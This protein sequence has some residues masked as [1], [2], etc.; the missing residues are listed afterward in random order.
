MTRRS[1]EQWLHDLKAG[2]EA[3]SAALADLRA[4]LLSGLPYAL[5]RW[6]SPSDPSFE[7]L[8][9]ETA[10]DALLKILD[11]LHTFEGRSQFTTWA[12]KIAVN[13]ALSKLRR[14]Q[15]QDVSLDELVGEEADMITPGLDADPAVGPAQLAEQRDMLKRVNRIIQE[16]L[17]EK[18]R[19][20]LMARLVY[21]MPA[22]RIS[23]EMRMERNALYKLL[24]DARENLKRRLER[25]GLTAQD[26][27]SVFSV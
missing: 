27:L 22:E 11:N 16:E 20:A 8:I 13:L 23:E 26:V 10:Q 3:Q 1:N 21:G 6:L 19:K 12:Y 15:W 14:R 4:A 9:E 2:G 7:P 24:H 17:T 25:E 18:Q 5:T